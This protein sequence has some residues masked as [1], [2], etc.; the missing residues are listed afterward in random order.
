M[1]F[2]Q[3]EPGLLFLALGCGGRQRTVTPQPAA[4]AR[5]ATT[6]PTTPVR[7]LARDALSPEGATPRH[8]RHLRRRS[9]GPLAPA[10]FETIKTGCSG[11][12]PNART[13]P[14]IR[15]LLR[16]TGGVGEGSWAKGFF[17]DTNGDRKFDGY[18]L[19]RFSAS[20]QSV[21]ARRYLGQGRGLRATRR[22]SP[23]WLSISSGSSTRTSS[24]RG[25]LGNIRQ[26]AFRAHHQQ[27]ALACEHRRSRMWSMECR[28]RSSTRRTRTTTLAR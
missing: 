11:T 7:T 17:N 13:P 21:G 19:A 12:M 18:W 24:L 8:R 16:K 25:S 3:P 26:S 23:S 28:S 14:A 27:H 1:R 2:Y 5:P 6:P 9:E 20:I 15:S 4:T 10:S 22:P